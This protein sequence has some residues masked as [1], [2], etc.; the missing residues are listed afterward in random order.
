MQDYASV[1]SLTLRQFRLLDVTGRIAIECLEH[2]QPLVDVRVQF[3][4]LANV[5]HSGVVHIEHAYDV[6]ST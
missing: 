2:V 1:H 4:E 3:L 6:Q 5:H